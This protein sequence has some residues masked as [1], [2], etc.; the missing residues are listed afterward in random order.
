MTGREALRF[1]EGVD[2]AHLVSLLCFERVSDELARVLIDARCSFVAAD[3]QY[4]F[5]ISEKSQGT[6]AAAAQLAA[7]VLAAPARGSSTSTIDLRAGREPGVG[8]ALTNPINLLH[9]LHA[10]AAGVDFH[11]TV[12][13]YLSSCDP[14]DILPFLPFHPAPGEGGEGTSVVIA[15]RVLHLVD[16]HG[17]E[18]PGHFTVGGLEL[19][20]PGEALRS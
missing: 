7:M 11:P 18:V 16:D 15:V 2:T 3:G 5:A 8:A 14:D 17:S 1:T 6:S 20:L 10:Q 4:Y 19:Q 12:N 13:A 9:W